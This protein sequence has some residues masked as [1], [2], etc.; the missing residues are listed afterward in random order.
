MER[1]SEWWNKL[2]T[3]VGTA[4]SLAIFCNRLDSFVQT[5]RSTGS[6]DG[7]LFKKLLVYIKFVGQKTFIIANSN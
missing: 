6:A 2:Q 4:E 5:I 1:T 3:Y 7:L